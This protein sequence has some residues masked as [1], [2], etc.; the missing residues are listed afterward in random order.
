MSIKVN[1]VIVQQKLSSYAFC[2]V[3]IQAIDT[4]IINKALHGVSLQHAAILE[5]MRD[6][7]VREK[8][9]L[10]EWLGKVPDYSLPTDRTVFA[11][12]PE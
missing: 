4:R 6:R 12:E 2:A 7:L 10:L 9:Q 5:K 1:D 11:P 8:T 3:Q